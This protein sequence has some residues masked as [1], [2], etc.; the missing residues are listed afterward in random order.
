MMI[1]LLA[2]TCAWL[3]TGSDS[4]GV[5]IPPCEASGELPE[6]TVKEE[7]IGRSGFM[8]AVFTG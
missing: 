4:E 5:Q 2:G 8:P 7:A 3:T 6:D 1:K